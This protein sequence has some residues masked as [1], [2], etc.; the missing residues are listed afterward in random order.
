MKR[1]LNLQNKL[2]LTYL[3]VALLTVL[4]ATLIIHVTSS[5]TLLSLVQEQQ[6]AALKQ[7]V[8]DYYISNGSLDGFFNYYVEYRP[9]G[10]PELNQ[11]PPDKPF[12]NRE[13]RG[14]FG[15]VDA[16][17]VA[18]LPIKGID[19][20]QIVSFELNARSIPVEVDSQTIAWIL[21]DT[22]M[23]FKLNP[24]KK[25]SSAAPPWPPSWPH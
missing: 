22:S 20:G 4:V 6:T 24:E 9:A 16:H 5:Q 23:Q 7:T 3:G 8:Q 21:Q 15:L 11:S 10:Q 2:I 13:V 19:V 17:K 25:P 1:S 14:V 18:V 12:E